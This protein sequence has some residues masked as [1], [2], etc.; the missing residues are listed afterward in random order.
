MITYFYLLTCRCS[1]TN[2]H[3]Y[4]PVYAIYLLPNQIYFI[5]IICQVNTVF[6]YKCQV[7]IHQ[8]VHYCVWCK[9]M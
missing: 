6:I 5:S 4:V 9:Y 1:P 7:N 8:Q 3:D 2:I